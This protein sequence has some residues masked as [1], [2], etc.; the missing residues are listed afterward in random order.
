MKNLR[1]A[2]DKIDTD[3]DGEITQLEL[4]V[5]FK[6]LGLRVADEI[7]DEMIR[8]VDENGDGKI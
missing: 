2:F 8:Q 5:L 1:A 3:K 6:N 7:I 4:K